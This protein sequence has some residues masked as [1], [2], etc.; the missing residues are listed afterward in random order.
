VRGKRKEERREN[1]KDFWGIRERK[2][3]KKEGTKEYLYMYQKLVK[4]RKRD[5]EGGRKRDV[6]TWRERDW[7]HPHTERDRDRQRQR[8]KGGERGRGKEQRKN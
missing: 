7:R 3:V 5:R 1:T 8:Q 2:E 6:V 4:A